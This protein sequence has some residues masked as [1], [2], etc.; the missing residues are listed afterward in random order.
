MQKII[1]SGVV[2]AKNEQD[3]IQ[4]CLA[5]LRFC[6][7]ILVIDDYSED[8]TVPICEEYKA[9][10]YK[11]KLNS[12]YAAQ[13]N[14]A[15]QK[16]KGKWVLFVDADEIIS[17][18]LANEILKVIKVE[19]NVVGYYLKRYDYLWGKKI[20]RGEIGAQ[21]LL[22]I[23]QKSQGTW[24]RPV[25]EVWL[26][27]GETSYLMNPILHYPHQSLKDFI[28]SVDRHSTIHAIANQSEGKKSNLFKI[29]FWPVAKF[30]QNW[31]LRLGFL[32]GTVGIIAAL[33]MSF[34]SYLA[35]SKLW[36][37]QRKTSS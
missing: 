7:E 33:M 21:R 17:K 12:D 34:H 9:I 14:F 1:L 5:S 4:R 26:M 37:L 16:A 15:L 29:L 13:R 28:A 20:T 2:I 24:V 27:K 32:D 25:H 36:L 22:R 6:D 18:E 23:G 35:W 3:N 19:E 10:V 30:I 31:I 8:L 11:H